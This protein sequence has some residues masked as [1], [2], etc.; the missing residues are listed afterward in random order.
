MLLQYRRW[1]HIRYRSLHG[2]LDC[3]GLALIRYGN[4]NRFAYHDLP[5]AHRDRACWNFIQRGEPPLTKLL[6]SAFLVK[7]YDEIRLVGLEICGRIVKR[8][9]TIFA[10]ANQS[11]IDWV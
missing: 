2:T 11:N 8:K 4:D 3:A 9:M 7:V 10:N 1:A 5:Y 6:C